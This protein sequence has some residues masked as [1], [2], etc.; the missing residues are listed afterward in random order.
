MLIQKG[1]LRMYAF[2]NKLNACLGASVTLTGK[3]PALTDQD[4]PVLGTV[5]YHGLNQLFET[6]T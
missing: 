6:C 1:S 5:T 3:N 2:Q 4:F